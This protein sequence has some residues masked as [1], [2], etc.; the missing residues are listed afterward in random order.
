MDHA[1]GNVQLLN[2]C[3]QN[4]VHAEIY[5]EK[6]RIYLAGPGRTEFAREQAYGQ[7]ISFLPLT[8][9]VEGITLDRL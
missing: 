7:Y 3:L 1:L 6:N 4:D 9:S 5:D 2:Q 8:E